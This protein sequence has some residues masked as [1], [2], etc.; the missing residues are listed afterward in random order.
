MV[1]F[2]ITVIVTIERKTGLLSTT[3]RSDRRRLSSSSSF[4]VVVF[5]CRRRR[6]TLSF[7]FHT[8]DFDCCP[9]VFELRRSVEFQLKKTSFLFWC[10][11][12]ILE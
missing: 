2:L 9:M 5:R 1:A 11:S 10:L 12:D 4:V 8:P 3:R 6:I 7:L